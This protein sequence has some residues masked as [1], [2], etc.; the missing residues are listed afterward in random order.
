[1]R[2][3]RSQRERAAQDAQP[4]DVSWAGPTEQ[5][6]REY[7]A[8]KLTKHSV[9]KIEVT[10]RTTFCRVKAGGLT[11]EAYSAF[12]EAAQEIAAQPWD[13]LENA[14]GEGSAERDIWSQE[15]TFDRR[16]ARP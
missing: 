8:S 14:G 10:C 16:G 15:F 1:V 5:L 11:F 7:F 2:A 9:N 4:S 6:L 3:R 13:E 12:H